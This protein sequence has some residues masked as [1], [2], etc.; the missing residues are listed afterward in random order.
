M[1]TI[2]TINFPLK[3]SPAPKRDAYYKL[4]PW[5]YRWFGWLCNW[6]VFTIG[7]FGGSRW[8]RRYSIYLFRYAILSVHRNEYHDRSH[9]ERADEY[10]KKWS[11]CEKECQELRLLVLG[12]KT[13]QTMRD[14]MKKSLGVDLDEGRIL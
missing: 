11:A 4:L 10:L 14:F 13:D 3:K 8:N 1:E 7:E 5:K 12:D 6:T 9:E 2:V